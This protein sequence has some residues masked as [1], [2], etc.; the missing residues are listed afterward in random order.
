[1]KIDESGKLTLQISV[2]INGPI[3]EVEERIQHALNGAG[4]TL[5]EKALEQFDTDGSPVMT[6]S[7]KWTR[8]C[9]NTQTYQTPYGG[10]RVNRHVYQT[11]R[12]GK[13]YVPLEAGARIVSCA[14]PRFAM[15]IASKYA[16]L[17][18]GA[19]V[20]DL[21]DNH[22]RSTSRATLQR[23]ADCVG[24]IAAAKEQSWSYETP[25]LDQAISS[26]V[27]SLDGA[28][29]L[30]VNDGWREAMVGALSLYDC[31]GERQHTTYFGSGAT[32]REGGVFQT[33]R[34]R[35]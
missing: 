29:L 22:A 11:S 17:N 9:T 18:A 28:M 6:G 31:D 27:C 24:A 13:T 30:T 26:V 35:A 21:R 23:I 32:I 34:T 4:C 15:M 12:G 14:T 25:K 33:L 2:D 8:R 10:V 1:M 16:R 7:I 19:V 20:A 3:L 5:T